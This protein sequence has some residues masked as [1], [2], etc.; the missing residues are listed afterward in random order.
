M[1]DLATITLPL[2]SVRTPGAPPGAHDLPAYCGELFGQFTRADPRG[3]G[4]VWRAGPAA[5][6]GV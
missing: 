4:G 3:G 5:P 2:P 6:G 1:S